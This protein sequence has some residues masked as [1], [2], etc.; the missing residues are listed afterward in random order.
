MKYFPL[1]FRKHGGMG[2]LI[3]TVSVKKSKGSH[4]FY[5]RNQHISTTEYM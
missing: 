2:Q 5:L 3:N 4:I 1:F